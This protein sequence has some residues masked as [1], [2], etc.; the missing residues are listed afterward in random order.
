MEE[1]SPP[2][3]SGCCNRHCNS[4]KLTQDSVKYTI[5]ITIQTILAYKGE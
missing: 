1:M 5:D 4:R 2:I 3:F